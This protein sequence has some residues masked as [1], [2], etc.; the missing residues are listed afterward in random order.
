MD[1][2]PPVLRVVVHRPDENP[3]FT[4]LCAGYELKQWRAAALADHLMESLPEFCLSYS[5]YA[6]MTGKNAVALIR[7]AAQRV[8]QTDKY[9]KRGEFGELLLHVALRQVFN[10]IPA[11]SKIYYKDSAND[12]VKGFD[13]AHVIASEHTL[14]LWLGE[15]KFYVDVGAAI[16]DVVTELQKHTSVKYL[17]NE[18]VAIRNKIDASWPHAA[19]LERLL[20]ENV[21]LDDIFDATC[22]P[23]LLTYDGDVTGKYK[24]CSGEYEAELLNEFTAVFEQFKAS[25]LPGDLRIHLFLIPLATK[26]ALLAELHKK[27]LA[28][29]TI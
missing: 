9:S 10:T 6:A 8:Y 19:R 22:I 2:R 27:L 20:D 18:F 5:E 4:G 23:V 11:I 14:E 21:S 12:T 26:E 24:E 15:V 25:S 29:Q 7:Q 28:W 17:R 16:R 13:A 1:D 3:G